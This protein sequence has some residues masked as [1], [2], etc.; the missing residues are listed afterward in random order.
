[1]GTGTYSPNVINFVFLFV[2]YININVRFVRLRFTKPS[3][4][5]NGSIS[6]LWKY[7]SMVLPPTSTKVAMTSSPMTNSDYQ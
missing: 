3:R 5:T 6:M 7:K 4:T 2:N 1:M